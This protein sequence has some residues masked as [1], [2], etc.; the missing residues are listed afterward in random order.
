MNDNELKKGFRKA[1]W[2]VLAGV[3]YVVIFVGLALRTNNPPRP[4]GWDMGGTPF[5]P[6]SSLPADGYYKPTGLAPPRAQ[7]GAP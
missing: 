6:A 4:K 2:L 3:A 7:E 5:V 1:W